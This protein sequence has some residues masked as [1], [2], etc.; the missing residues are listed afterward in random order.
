MKI[1]IICRKEKEDFSDEHVIPDSINGYY[2]I[3]SVCTTCNSYLGE[4]VDSKLVNHKF[5]EF[6]RYEL[7]IKGKSGIKPNPFSGIHTLRDDSEQKVI[8]TID[9]N[10]RTM[11]KLLPKIS[12]IKFNNDVAN[13]SFTI[14]ASDLHLK[15]IIT[16][17][18][19]KR[20]GFNKN[21]ILRFQEL[22]EHSERPI[23]DTNMSIDI[24]EFRIGLLKIAYEFAVD[25]IE[26]Y[27]NDNLA[28]CISQILYKADLKRMENEII[29]FGDG[30]NKVI[31]EPLSNL[32]DF[33]NK[34]H[35]LILLAVEN[36][37]LV[38]Q[39]NLFE[40]FSI[41]IKLS[42]SSRFLNQEIII[43]AN[44]TKNGTFEKLNIDELIKRTFSS[45]EYRFQY[46]LHDKES[47]SKFIEFQNNKDFDFLQK[48]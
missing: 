36:I 33:E 13:I 34:N 47:L 46:C 23:I 35:Y 31:L 44:D 3:Y 2:H 21:S 26:D 4:K 48:W 9:E 22:R 25:S 45:V 7:G 27:Y 12:P 11:P 6:Q 5:I 39:I 24:K 1:C 40:C 32:I 37:G 38:C 29:F 15:D 28:I 30:F 43:G 42:D 16:E 19:L 18:I 41:G 8:I 17:K 14:D 10:G 20:N